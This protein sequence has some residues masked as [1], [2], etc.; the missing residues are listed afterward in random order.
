MK[1]GLMKQQKT[2]GWTE[3]LMEGGKPIARN[4][5]AIQGAKKKLIRTG[6]KYSRLTA[7]K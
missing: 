4:I 1:I 5:P 2:A 3:W 6:W 7:S